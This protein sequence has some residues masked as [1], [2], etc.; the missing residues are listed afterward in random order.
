MMDDNLN[1]TMLDYLSDQKIANFNF[2]KESLIEAIKHSDKYIYDSKSDLIKLKYRP[3][4][5]SIVFRDVP[6]E[7]QKEEKILEIFDLSGEKHYRADIAKIEELNGLFF[8]YFE[9]EDK[10][11]E[12]FKWIEKLKESDNVK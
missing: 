7:N 6:K 1:L 8:V 3:K 12:I 9:N 10:T 5:K 4:R 11:L 2:N